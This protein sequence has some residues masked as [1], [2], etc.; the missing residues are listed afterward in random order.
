MLSSLLRYGDRLSMA[1]SREV[2][3][4]FCDHRIAEFAFGIPPDLLVGAGE[5]KRVLRLAIRGLV[6]EAIVRR[7]KQGFVPPQNGW[8]LG[9][10]RDW[11]VD[12]AENPGPVGEF[13]DRSSVSN[14]A[15]A[16]LETRSR[17]VVSLWDMTNLLAWSRFAAAPMQE[18][19]LL[20]ATGS[21]L[22]VGA[23]ETGGCV[24]VGGASG[25]SDG[26]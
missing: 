5:V 9:V 24:I 18:Q 22:A 21:R 7:P 17:E 15:S 3:L 19:S 11:I 6:P 8:L 16:D 4:P 1:H 25:D 12:L 20:S 26:P 10:L 14:L 23:A 2:R 13:L